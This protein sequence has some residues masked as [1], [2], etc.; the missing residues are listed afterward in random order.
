MK[1]RISAY[2][3]MAFV[4]FGFSSFFS[5]DGDD[6]RSH[7]PDAVIVT[8]E[9][10]FAPN[11]SC[12]TVN[13]ERH[14]DFT[15][16]NG[17]RASGTGADSCRFVIKMRPASTPWTYTKVCIGWTRTASGS[18]TLNYEICVYDT[19]GAGGAPGNLIAVIPGQTVTG[20]PIYPLMT[21]NSSTVSIPVNGAVYI[22]ARWNSTAAASIFMSSDES[23]ST[24]LWAGY[25][26]LGGPPTWV[27][28]QSAFTS[29]RCMCIRTEGQPVQT[30]CNYY[31]SMWCPAGTLPNLPAGVYFQASAWLGDTLYVHCPSTAGA[32]TNTIRRYTYGGSWTLGVPM[33]VTKTGGSLTAC[34]GKLYYIGGGTSSILTGT[35]TVH[36]YNPSTGTWTARANLPAA[37]SAHGAANWGDSVI[38]VWGG[39]YTGAATNLSVHYYRVGTNIWGTITNSIPSGQGRRTFASGISGNKL[40]MSCGY[41]TTYLKST[42]VGTIGTNASQLTWASAPDCPTTF[43]GLSRPGGASYGLYFYMIA[44]EQAGGGYHT[45][46]YVFRFATNTWHPTTISPKPTG[47]SNIFNGCV[48]KCINDTV[49]VF[50]PG[51]YN[52]TASPN[53]EMIGC[54]ATIT[55]NSTIIST[56]PNVYSLAQNYPNPFNP[57]TKILF[58][59]PKAG[60]VKL[61]VYDILGKE[62]NVLVNDYR[63]AGT[64]QVEFNASNLASGVYLYRIEAGEF[65][66]T[67]RMMLIK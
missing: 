19:T 40:I 67:K 33:P 12:A 59:L 2:L 62:V 65:S 54:G 31:S 51:G 37:L 66:E 52:G 64:H 41:N 17:Y 1:F 36:E 5:S 53:F 38:F 10:D 22:G 25:R 8:S 47:M 14:D 29:Y 30:V 57:S 42:Y 24:P 35:N 27:T 6:V 32:G 26:G 55:G 45:S 34:N 28:I 50:V 60:D 20:I 43:T 11:D 16:E 7:Y 9:T 58:S 56:I 15:H 21:W 13:P 23:V 48:A 39:P 18:T 4:F 46:A 3:L 61:V 63:T 49:K 44:G